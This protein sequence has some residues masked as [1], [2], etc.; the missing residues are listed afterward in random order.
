MINYMQSNQE[1]S[2]HAKVID[3]EVW[4]KLTH[5]ILVRDS[6]SSLKLLDNISDVY[7]IDAKSVIKDYF[8]YIIR[9][10]SEFITKKFL[11]FVEVVM[12]TGDP[13][14]SHL[15]SYVILS[16]QQLFVEE[17]SAPSVL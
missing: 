12:H 3:E 5:T 1:L 15:R 8:N 14:V 6:D 7:N 4:R 17:S 16:L 13:N 2:T 9:Y 11:K 10:R